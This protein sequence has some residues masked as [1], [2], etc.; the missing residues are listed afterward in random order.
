MPAVC[1][2]LLNLTTST[3]TLTHY[4]LIFHKIFLEIVQNKEYLRLYI[5]YSYIKTPQ[6]K[7]KHS[8]KIKSVQHYEPYVYDPCV[9]PITHLFR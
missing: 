3:Q 6:R 7:P 1:H 2:I 5:R 9:T 4:R 8:L